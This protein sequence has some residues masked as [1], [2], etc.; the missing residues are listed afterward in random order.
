MIYEDLKTIT[1]DLEKY[2]G[3]F[4][5]FWSCGK[6]VLDENLKVPAQ[7]SIFVKEKSVIFKINPIKWESFNYKQKLFIICHEMYHIYLNH[8]K[9]IAMLGNYDKMLV[10]IAADIVTNE[11]LV[12]FFGFKREEID[13]ENNFVWL[14]KF[15]G[16]LPNKN[17]E[18]YIEN[19][20]VSGQKFS[21][22]DEH[23]NINVDE[24]VM[25]NILK[26]MSQEE[27]SYLASSSTDRNYF[28]ISSKPKIISELSRFLN[29]KSKDDVIDE[30]WIKQSRR[31][32][33]FNSDLFLPGENENEFK[34]ELPEI[35]FFQ[36][37]S[38][39]CLNLSNKFYSVAKGL[40]Y[41]K[42]K[43]KFH[44]FD[45][46][47][48]EI[49]INEDRLI[50]GGGTSFSCIEKYLLSKN[51]YPKFVVIITDGHGDWANPK[52]PER[53]VWLLSENN[54]IYTPFLSK[55]FLLKNYEL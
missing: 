17:M 20:K 37:V 42:F 16:L 23:D 14:D 51:T 55:I 35:W 24:E 39:S 15:P 47:V 8:G 32:T 44:C 52:F 43:I 48:T 53:W 31:T 19:I 34:K 54:T 30:T 13:P 46:E 1:V 27:R 28:P 49:S 11:A 21:S 6:V 50:G 5:I 3:F 18:Y 2:H 45:T 36:D 7:V 10:N 33:F 22:F 40:K 38:N 41:Q 26:K 25:K 9:R 29:K 12:N 4:S